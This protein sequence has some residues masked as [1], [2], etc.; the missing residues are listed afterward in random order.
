MYKPLV[1]V[2]L[3]ILFLSVAAN[4]SA[5]DE[6]L[7][8][9]DDASAVVLCSSSNCCPA[10]CDFGPRVPRF[11]RFAVPRSERVVREA[12]CVEAVYKRGPLG[13]CRLTYVPCESCIDSC[14]YVGRTKVVR[15][16]NRLVKAQ[17][18][19]CGCEGAMPEAVE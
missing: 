11:A 3:A 4:W 13:R 6:M 12:V 1:P 17:V 16:G 5:A 10:F 14:D 19:S 9:V 18:C 7:L 15:L 8:V 2:F